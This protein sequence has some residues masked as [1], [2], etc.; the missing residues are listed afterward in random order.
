MRNGKLSAGKNII[1][2]DMS[3]LAAGSY[4]LVAEWR[5]GFKKVNQLI[6]Q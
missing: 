4:N 3:N 2:L 1:S 5:S 6:K